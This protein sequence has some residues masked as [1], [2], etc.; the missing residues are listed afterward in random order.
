MKLVSYSLKDIYLQAFSATQRWK[1]Y[2]QNIISQFSTSDAD[3]CPK[4]AVNG[5]I[6]VT[7]DHAFDI[8]ASAKE[9]YRRA[10][11]ACTSN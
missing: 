7:W 6:H 2:H 5:H 1:C 11:I 8:E 4:S 9:R 3:L 10:S